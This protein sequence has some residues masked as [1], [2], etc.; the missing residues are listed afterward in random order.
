MDQLVT[1]VIELLFGLVFVGALVTWVRRRDTLSRD[2]TLVFSGLT[3][4]FA[5]E[6]VSR[7]FGPVPRWLT[8]GAAFLLLAQPVLTLRL[9]SNAGLVRGRLMLFAF[10]AYLV[11]SPPPAASGSGV[12][13]SPRRLGRR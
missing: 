10:A 5:L 13:L 11:T 12:T 4:L 3:F 6:L 1:L 9:V 7:A 8:Y 2:V